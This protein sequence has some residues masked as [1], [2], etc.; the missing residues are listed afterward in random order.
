[1]EQMTVE[2]RAES[3]QIGMQELI[4]Q[5]GI[6]I[7]ANIVPRMLGDVLQAEVQFAYVPVDGWQQPNG[8]TTVET[9]VKEE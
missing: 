5:Y 7:S 3:F 1:M 4:E 6:A 2:Q 9:P 8:T